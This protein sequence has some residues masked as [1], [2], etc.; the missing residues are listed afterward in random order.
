[1]PWWAIG[2]AGL[3]LLWG[4]IYLG[5]YNGG[6]QGDVFN[7]EANYHPVSGPPED[8]NSPEVMVRTG[9]KVFTAN[10]VVCH[11]ASGLGV[12]GQYPPLVGS[13]W[14]IGDA[15]KR[16][17][18]ILLHG[19]QGTVHVKGGIYNNA[20][21]AWNTVLTD[22]QIAQ[23]LSYVRLKLGGNAAAPITEKQ[24]D[25]ARAQTKDRTDPWS[26][27]ELLAIPA[28]PIDGG[29]A[30]ADATSKAGATAPATGNPPNAGFAPSNLP[31]L[32][33]ARD[34]P[35][36][37]PR[38]LDKNRFIPDFAMSIFA[39]RHVSWP[40][41]R[42]AMTPTLLRSIFRRLPAL[43]LLAGAAI[44][45]GAT[46]CHA[47][48]RQSNLWWSPDAVTVHG[49]KIDQLLMFIFW[50]TLAVFIVTQ[51]VYIYFIVKYRRR[52]GVKA[53]YSHGNNR[54]EIIWTTIP[55]AIFILLAVYSDKLW[56]QLRGKAPSDA[57]TIDIVAYQFGFHIRSPGSD[58]M[59][60]KSSMDWVEMGSNNFGLDLKNP[61]PART[62]IS[63]RKT[64]SPFRS[65]GPST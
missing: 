9:E 50:L 29:A 4:G 56:F 52:K 35:Q 20:M 65:V 33:W 28:G 1:M 41:R 46:P 17:Q 7:E 54:L 15:P 53:V 6:W 34:P 14:V 23:V 18:Q 51:V 47:E 55:A 57:L 2:A 3:L 31:P 13:E 64:S 30:A 8:P 60:G 59:L 24:M 45:L 62:M 10:C 16:L 25:D 58:G 26:E 49:H 22:K 37:R 5:Q 19:L 48:L 44:L 32:R 40:G 21:P 38:H 11:Q 36:R 39:P 42:P 63:R 43:L 27:A 12:A 61:D